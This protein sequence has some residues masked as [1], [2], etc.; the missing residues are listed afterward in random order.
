MND[1]AFSVHFHEALSFEFRKLSDF[2]TGS[3]QLTQ[4]I[5][6]VNICTP[7]HYTL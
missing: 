5:I 2:N 7:I 1:G 6:F 4:L 3:T